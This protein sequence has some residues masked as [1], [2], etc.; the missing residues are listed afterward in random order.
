M[1]TVLIIEDNDSLRADIVNFIS[2]SGFN[3]ID[4]ANGLDGIDQAMEHLP[5][6]IVCDILMPDVDGYEVLSELRLNSTTATIPFIFLT[7]LSERASVRKGMELGADDYLTKPFTFEELLSAIKVRLDRRTQFENERFRTLLRDMIRS[8]D[9]ERRNLAATLDDDV[10]QRIGSLRFALEAYMQMPHDVALLQ[11]KEAINLLD[12]LIAQTNRLVYSL[13]P[14]LL[15]HMGLLPALLR[16][17]NEIQQSRGLEVNFQHSRLD[18]RLA[19]DLETAI[20]R[21]IQEALVNAADHA[22]VSSALVSI[23][24]DE[25]TIYLQ[26]EDQG[27]GFE[28]EPTLRSQLCRGLLEMRERTLSL[29]GSLVIESNPRSGTSVKASL[30]AVALPPRPVSATTAADWLNLPPPALIAAAPRAAVEEPGRIRVLI[31]DSQPLVRT[32]LQTVLN[33]QDNITVVGESGNGAEALALARRLVP[34]VLIIDRML[35]EMTG[36]ELAEEISVQQPQTKVLLLDSSGDEAFL[37]EAWKAGIAGYTLKSSS[38]GDLLDAVGE[39]V[40]GKRYVSPTLSRQTIEMYLDRASTSEGEMLSYWSLT[41]REREVLRLVAEGYRN[42]EVA[43]VLVLSVRTVETHR[44][45]MMRK[46][47]LHSRADL[48]RFAMQHGI[49][50]LTRP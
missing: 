47:D 17:F 19:A 36:L 34:D 11:A 50:P 49:V 43:E 10:I 40:R 23:S 3:A 5:D 25:D 27:K 13:H 6:V 15:E 29:N 46:L 31:A 30:P 22:D 20:F 16:Y 24:L 8:H 33:A 44:A 14:A 4:A 38:T 32:A 2:F 18:R 21:I 28:L 37:V 26:V 35:P 9:Q 42:S 41:P 12:N 45:N 39:I 1:Q 7:A 48:V